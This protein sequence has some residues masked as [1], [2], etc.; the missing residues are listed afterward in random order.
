MKRLL[1]ILLT[2]VCMTTVQAQHLSFMGVELGNKVS[3]FDKELINK[4]YM[5]AFSHSIGDVYK[6]GTFAGYDA[7]I[8]LIRQQPTKKVSTASAKILGN[9]DLSDAVRIVED[10][11]GK[12]VAKYPGATVT[13]ISEGGALPRLSVLVHNAY[14]ERIN[15]QIDEDGKV[16]VIYMGDLTKRAPE[17]DI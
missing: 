15:L 4:G 13:D 14:D 7:E 9:Y 17:N 8:L 1:F 16:Q 6:N 3:K 11:R 5:H 12:I 2:V 10:L